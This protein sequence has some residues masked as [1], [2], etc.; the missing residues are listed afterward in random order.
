MAPVFTSPASATFTVL[1]FGSYSASTTGVPTPTYAVSGTLPSGVTFNTSTGVLSGTPASGTAGNYTL[2]LSATNASGTGQINPFTLTVA[3]LPQTITFD[4][5]GEKPFSL[6]PVTVSATASSGL[7]VSFVSTTPDQCEVNVDQVTPL[8]IGL[9]KIA[10]FQSGNGDYAAASDVTQGFNFVQGP[11]TITFP[12]QSPST[13]GYASGG[14]FALSP[15]ASASSGLDITY[16]SL[17]TDVCNFVAGSVAINDVGVCTIQASQNGN[18]NFLPADPISRSI[19]IGIGSQLIVFDLFGQT[20]PF[21]PNGSFVISPAALASSGLPITY[22][23]QSPSICTVSGMLVTMIAPGACQ[24]QA[25]QPGDG[26]YYSAATPLV[27]TVTINASVPGAPTIDGAVP[28]AGSAEVS[29][30]APANNGGSPITEYTVTCNPGNI[31]ATGAASPITVTGLTNNVQYTCSVRANNAVGSSAAS[32]TVN[33]TPFV[34]TGADLWATVCSACHTPVPSGIQLNGAGTTATV[35]AHVR[36]AQSEMAV[37]PSVQALSNADLALIA[38]YIN[39]NVPNIVVTT[40]PNAPKTISVA[41]HVTLSGSVAFNAVEVVTP[42]TS[43][44]LGAWFGGGRSITYTP[45]SGFSG[46]DSFTY[47]PKNTT[48]GLLGDPRTVT[49]NVTASTAT[50]TVEANVAGL[51]EGTVNSSPFGIVNCYMAGGVIQSGFCNNVVFPLNTSITLTATAFDGSMSGGWSGVS[52][53][54]GNSGPTCTF[55]LSSNT[56]V[57]ATFDVEIT[58]NVAPNDLNDD[59]RSDI[60]WRTNPGGVGDTAAWLMNGTAVLAGA[61]L[62][63][64]SPYQVTHA[65]DFDGDGKADLAFQHLTAGDVTLFRMDGTTVVAGAGIL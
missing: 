9:C 54:G 65:G 16:S 22:S 18:E 4:P 27:R 1:N 34:T 63:A 43:G 19:T 3:L 37:T 8:Q 61:G 58:A 56:T 30:I 55:T 28:G 14:T 38:A 24:I 20:E 40:T 29:F 33:V 32:A 44:S 17:T 47:R 60:I 35:L 59:G 10:A 62:T 42:P 7:P 31:T 48:S 2:V 12:A 21:V 23:S 46:T 49:I 26:V 52:C 36:T 64:G 45:N 6:T 51:G 5:I 11:Q 25:A 57:T 50:L 53:A 41:S 13:V 39:D 15:P